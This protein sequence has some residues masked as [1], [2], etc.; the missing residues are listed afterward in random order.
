MRRLRVLGMSERGADL[1]L[2][3]PVAVAC[4]LAATE[5]KAQGMKIAN[6]AVRECVRGNECVFV[7]VRWHVEK[8]GEFEKSAVK[9]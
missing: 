3:P 8:R 7:N 5:Q 6:C 4:L 2:P 9:R 1:L